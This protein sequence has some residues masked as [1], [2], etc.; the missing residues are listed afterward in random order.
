MKPARFLNF[1]GGYPFALVSVV[2]VTA[3]LLPLRS[4]LTPAQ[5]MLL[6]VPM[7]AWTGRASGVRP[8]VFAAALSVP[9]VASCFV[10]PYG[11]VAAASVADRVTLAVFFAVTLFV[12]VLAG[13]LR[14]RARAA[15]QKQREVALLNR[16]SS[17]LVSEKSVGQMGSFIANEVVTVLDASRCALYLH[18]GDRTRLVAEAGE[19][20]SAVQEAAAVDDVLRSGSPQGVSPVTAATDAPD[21]GGEADGETDIAPAGAYLPIAGSEGPIGVLYVRPLAGAHEYAGRGRQLRAVADLAAAFMVRHSLEEAAAIA[22]ATRESDRLKSTLVSSVSHELKTPLAAVTAR[23]T[24]LLG[25]QG[26][27]GEGRLREEL[28]A[29]TED[30]T[31]LDSSIRDLVDVSRLESDA[32]KPKLD[33]YQL[34]EVLGTVANRVPVA[35]RSRVLFDIPLDLP[36]VRIDFAQIARAISNLVENGLA[37]TPAPEPVRVGARVLGSDLIV[38]VEDRGPGVGENEKEQVFEK[39]YR[40]TA[41]GVAPAGTGLGLAIVR[42]IVRSHGGRVW[43]ED[44]SPSGA[45]FVLSLPLEGAA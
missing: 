7:I 44:A 33:T 13:T 10:V 24:G 42:E 38:W 40:G 23:L 5:I 16:L 35:Q 34:S 37:Y 41:S 43:V 6:F 26:P 2:A 31:R 45:R 29:A 36:L 8:A 21:I 19:A 28:T 32:W 30:L 11:S 4:A 3:L 12:G 17:R 15:L 25:E 22:R 27:I 20:G 18:A 39:F 9:L 1:L 14:K